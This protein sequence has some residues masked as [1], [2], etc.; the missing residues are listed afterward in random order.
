MSWTKIDNLKKHY[1]DIPYYKDQGVV[2]YDIIQCDD[3][4]Q[5]W[6]CTGYEYGMQWD[7]LPVPAL[8]WKKVS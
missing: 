1:C 3:C 6:E 8:T 7:P 2:Q 4:G 5:K